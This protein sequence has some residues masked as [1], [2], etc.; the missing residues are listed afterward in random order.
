[1]RGSVKR[2]PSSV[3][4]GKQTRGRGQALESTHQ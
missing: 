1:M 4:E 2:A 3:D